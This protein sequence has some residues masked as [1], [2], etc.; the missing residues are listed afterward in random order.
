[1]SI[2]G[3]L[4]RRVMLGSVLILGIPL[5]VHTF[6]M[7]RSEY[8]ANI[9]DTFTMLNQLTESKTLY[10]EQM[11]RCQRDL[12]SGI[13]DNIPSDP[14]ERALFMQKEAKEY[15]IGEFLIL[16]SKNPPATFV[17]VDRKEKKLLVGIKF[18]E[19]SLLVITTP[20]DEL[21]ERLSDHV[22]GY[23][24][25]ISLIDHAGLIFLTTEKEL[26]DE[27]YA[28]SDQLLE[29]NAVPGFSN[30]WYLTSSEGRL[31][32]AA[33]P[34]EGTDYYLMLDLPERSIAAIQVED[35]IVRIGIFLLLFCVIGGLALLWLTRRIAKPLHALSSVMHRVSEGAVHVRYTPEWMGFEINAFGRQLNQMLDSLFASQQ[36]AER[37]RIARQRLAEEMRIGHQIQQS[38]LPKEFKIASLE[39][40]PGYHPALEV[41]G[42]FYDLFPL[43]DGRLLIAIADAAGKGISACLFSLSFRSMLRAAATMQ[44]DLASMVRTANELFLHDTAVSCFFITAWIGLYDPKRRELTFCSQGHPPALLR[45]DGKLLSLSTHGIALG[46]MVIEPKIERVQLQR[47]DELLLYTDGVIEAQNP[48]GALF[49][50]G[51]L[52]QLFQQR[53]DADVLMKE[54]QSFCSGAA[55]ADDLT[56]IFLRVNE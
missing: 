20:I 29:W 14:T 3:S 30:S 32:T 41:S 10:F 53:G 40:M 44:R 15:H 38:M 6:L 25:G 34:I 52:E 1:M 45:Q 26:Q 33:W 35:Y 18:D 43:S 12:L 11:V 16:K 5:V 50:M 56:F 55:Q 31:L 46:A 17:R 2:K 27:R 8:R 36:E 13:L 47:G 39:I 28:Q 7:Y 24:L 9:F 21:M 42:D 49:G 19:Q 37:E 22:W 4:A 54:I 48:E 51:R 23:P